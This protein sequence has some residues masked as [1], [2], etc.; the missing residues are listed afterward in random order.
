MERL[1]NMSHVAKRWWACSA[2]QTAGWSGILNGLKDIVS[3]WVQGPGWARE[4]KARSKKSS[5]KTS[6]I[7]R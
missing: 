3:V 4:V 5:K 1:S 7:G 2:Y 6:E